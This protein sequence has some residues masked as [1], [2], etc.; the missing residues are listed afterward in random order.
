MD[1]DLRDR[2]TRLWHAY[3]PGAE[4]P[5]V[6]YYATEPGCTNVAEPPDG[7]RCLVAQLIEVRRGQSLCFGIDNLGCSGGKRNTG[8]AQE[9]RPDFEHFLSCGLPGKISGERYK[10]S[11][12]SGAR[13][14][15]T[16]AQSHR[17][18]A[19]HRV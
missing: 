19:L 10:S 16:L 1:T 6:F 5:I 13:N 18:R 2:F 12:R 15:G 4:L 8:F 9:F 3:F 11:P 14:Y 17:A 7:F